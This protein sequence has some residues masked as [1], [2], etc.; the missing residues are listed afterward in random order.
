MSN[1]TEKQNSTTTQEKDSNSGNRPGLG[2][3]AAAR[4]ERLVLQF[5][6]AG[7]N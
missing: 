4:E 1:E 6:G 7:L 5:L 2:E 3:E